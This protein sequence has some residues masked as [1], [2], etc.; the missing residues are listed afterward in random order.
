MATLKQRLKH[1]EQIVEYLGAIETASF[2]ETQDMFLGRIT[3]SDF[4][5]A[6]QLGLDK[7]SF[8]L[9]DDV[10]LALPQNDDRMIR[11]LLG[12]K[13]SYKRGTNP[14]GNNAFYYCDDCGLELHGIHVAYVGAGTEYA[15]GEH[16]KCPRCGEEN[17]IFRDEPEWA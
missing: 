7:G 15:N 9:T 16:S 6:I 8:R 10:K 12:M 13:Y 4:Q 1:I 17:A 3:T 11:S 5:H 2:K 14:A